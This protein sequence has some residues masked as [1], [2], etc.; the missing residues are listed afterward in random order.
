MSVTMK[1][2]RIHIVNIKQGR[3]LEINKNTNI[4]AVYLK[5]PEGIEI[6]VIVSYTQK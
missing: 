3:K 6:L 5:V 4:F 1:L 2:D